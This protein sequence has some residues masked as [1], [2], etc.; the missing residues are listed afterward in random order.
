MD[1]KCGMR[2]TLKQERLT[3]IRRSLQG[4]ITRGQGL[5]PRLSDPE[6]DVLPI[7]LSPN[8]V[9]HLSTAPRDAQ[10][11]RGGLAAK[12]LSLDL[13]ERVRG[14]ADQEECRAAYRCP[15][16]HLGPTIPGALLRSLPP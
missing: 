16:R 4:S 1:L 2:E 15:A 5:E 11:W 12:R 7:K 10:V 6:S 9:A 8:D 14:H 3:H 13:I